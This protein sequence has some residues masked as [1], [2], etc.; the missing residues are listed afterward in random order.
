MVQDRMDFKIE[1]FMH[2][3]QMLPDGAGVVVGVSGGADSIALLM[4]LRQLSVRHAWHLYAVHVNHGLRGQEAD[5]DAEFVLSLCENMCI[6]C[7]V[8]RADIQTY[9]KEKHLSEEEAGREFRY[10]CFEE[11][12]RKKKADKIAV[13]H[14]GDDAAETFLLN[15]FRG[16]GIQGLTGIPV[17]RDHII[18][19]M[20][21]VSRDEIESWL[22]EHGIIW[23]TDAT[24]MQTHYVRNKIRNVILPYVTDEINTGAVRHI[25][26][27]SERLGRVWRYM[28]KEADRAEM[29]YV[30]Y[31]TNERS[32]AQIDLTL[33]QK[34]DVVICE[35]VLRRTVGKT[36]GSLKDITA[37][38]IRAVMHLAAQQTGR[39]LD[40]PYGLSIIRGYDTL[41]ISGESIDHENHN[42][43]D[44]NDLSEC[45]QVRIPGEVVLSD[46]K[47]LVFSTLDQ[48][49][50]LSEIPVNSCTKWLDYAKIKD[51]LCVRHKLPKDYLI[52][53][54]Y[55]HKKMLKKWLKDEKIPADRRDAL[56]VV[57]CGSHIVWIPGYRIS[58]YFKIDQ[59]T[60]NILV[61]TLKE[62]GV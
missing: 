25:R 50:S 29:L 33:F 59:N 38:H 42:Q 15:L 56:W 43:P 31:S 23:R 49:V 47:K 18:R 52:I 44:L 17:K 8:Y 27:A 36:A 10:K 21:T 61:I 51:G 24:N 22:K 58:D 37:R 6:P 53:D 11:V 30:H 2:E 28:E 19:P 20:L 4:I 40:F 60:E 45:F 3:Q 16:T 39:R 14:H 5:E 46:E 62:N 32:T 41:I 26:E 57:A 35:E 55:G 54:E 34:E 48:K 9:A 13:A 7:D 12:M 1:S